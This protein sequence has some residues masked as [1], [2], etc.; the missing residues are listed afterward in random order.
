M[1][2]GTWD[3]GPAKQCLSAIA[4]DGFMELSAPCDVE[5]CSNKV[6]PCA[7]K[8]L[9]LC[10]KHTQDREALLLQASKSAPV[11]INNEKQALKDWLLHLERTDQKG[12]LRYLIE[13]STKFFGSI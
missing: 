1:S 9:S 12:F 4:T 10:A 3:T 11:E 2:S 6:V 8:I 13:F 5:S 7:K